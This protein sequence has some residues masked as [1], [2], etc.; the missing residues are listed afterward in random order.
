MQHYCSGML[1]GGGG[2]VCGWGM[3]F[4]NKKVRFVPSDLRYMLTDTQNQYL[5]RTAYSFSSEDNA[6]CQFS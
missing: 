5:L 4:A 1:V 3:T 6:F 2:G